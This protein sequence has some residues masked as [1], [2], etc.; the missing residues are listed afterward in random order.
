MFIPDFHRLKPYKGPYL[1]VAGSS[2]N[3]T[4][5]G[6]SSCA[7]SKALLARC[8]KDSSVPVRP[9]SQMTSELQGSERGKPKI[10]SSPN[11]G[12]DSQFSMENHHAINRWSIYFYG[13]FSMAML[14]NQR[15]YISIHIYPIHIYT[16]LIISI[17]IYTYVIEVY[18]S[19]AS[20]IS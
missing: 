1:F 15:V 11:S 7:T 3:F 13:P 16:Y 4:P 2:L 5:R 19:H 9:L 18:R 10:T 17:H 6:C 14:N 8:A 20:M 12:Y